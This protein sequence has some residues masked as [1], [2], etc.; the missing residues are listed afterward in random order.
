MPGLSGERI[1][2]PIVRG[3]PFGGREMGT[4]ISPL[5]D[6]QRIFHSRDVEET[7]AFLR[8]K[9]FRF[10]VMSRD[11]RRLDVHINGVYLPGAFIGYIEYGA[12]VMVRATRARDDYWI[13]LPVRAA[14]RPRPAMQPWPAMHVAPPCAHRCRRTCCVRRQEARASMFR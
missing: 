5:L 12:P 6:R 10:D 3:F 14:L 7:R 1:I 2:H 4:S 8:D 11:A 9:E 13:Q